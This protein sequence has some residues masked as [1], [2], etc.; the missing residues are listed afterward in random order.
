[1][2]ISGCSN[3]TTLYTPQNTRKNSPTFPKEKLYA[4]T[5]AKNAKM[6]IYEQIA[7]DYDIRNATHKELCTI[8]RKLYDEGEISLFEHGLLTIKLE[9]PAYKNYSYFLTKADRNGKRDWI[10][11]YEARLAENTRIGNTKGQI[12]DRKL[13]DVLKLLQR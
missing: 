4:E 5:N 11:E 1:M 3:M 7:Q 8:S 13:I 9:L 10:A 6:D 2:R 12:Y